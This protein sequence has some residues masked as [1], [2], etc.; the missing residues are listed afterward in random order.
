[1]TKIIGSITVRA[2]SNLIALE[3]VGRR[4]ASVLPGRVQ[5]ICQVTQPLLA[6]LPF[7]V[8]LAEILTADD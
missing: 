1:M 6:A 4:G 3:I 8:S 7:F 2:A 5:W